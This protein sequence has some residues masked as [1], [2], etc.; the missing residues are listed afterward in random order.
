MSGLA[1]PPN[2]RSPDGNSGARDADG[3][4]V[5]PLSGVHHELELTMSKPRMRFTGMYWVCW[6]GSCF[7]VGATMDEAWIN[8]H[9]EQA[10]H[11]RWI[12]S[13][14]LRSIR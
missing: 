9:G 11:Q 14:G 5:R 12:D 4:E 10:H 2:A 6:T 1:A 3:H 8:Y 7:G 13:L